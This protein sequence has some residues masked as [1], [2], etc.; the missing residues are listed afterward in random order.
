MALF[1]SREGFCE[2]INQTM[3]TKNAALENIL[4]NVTSFAKKNTLE[5]FPM[6]ESQIANSIDFFFSCFDGKLFHTSCHA[7]LVHCKKRIPVILF[8]AMPLS[9]MSQ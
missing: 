3:A 1:S 5:N 9:L 8:S 2:Q 7:A 6:H 4:S